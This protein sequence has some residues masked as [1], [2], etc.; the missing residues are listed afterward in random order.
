MSVPRVMWWCTRHSPCSTSGEWCV[1][2]CGVGVRVSGVCGFYCP[3]KWKLLQCSSFYLTS[4]THTH[5]HAHTH[6][7]THTHTHMQIHVHGCIHHTHTH[8]DLIEQ[9]KTLCTSWSQDSTR[10]SPNNFQAHH[11]H[12]LI[13]TD[14]Q[15]R[16]EEFYL[17][18]GE[19]DP[20][21][22]S[23]PHPPQGHTL[24]PYTKL[25]PHFT[26]Y[27]S[28]PLITLAHPHTTH[29]IL[30]TPYTSL[31]LITSAHPHTTHK[32]LLA[33]YESLPL[34][35]SAH[36]HTTHKILLA[37]YE[38]LP[39]ITSA[40]PH[41]TQ[42]SLPHRAKHQLHIHFTQTSPPHSHTLHTVT[43]VTPHTPPPPPTDPHIGTVAIVTPLHRTHS[44]DARP[45][46]IDPLD[47][48]TEFSHTHFSRDD[49]LIS[50]KIEPDR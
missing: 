50:L 4:H 17:E 30:L 36:P 2:V 13:C 47:S 11:Y 12:T 15:K 29:K 9:C 48:A 18:R 42:L 45:P 46:P 22:S 10:V 49:D 33:L 19:S 21:E 39:H 34:I 20:S 37:L 44:T 35:T 43:I 23:P 27:E 5:A 25:F 6:T 3:E 1:A 7:H 16:R 26:L 38:S 41:T 40:H 32:I 24:T 31:P 28:L 8:T 14:E